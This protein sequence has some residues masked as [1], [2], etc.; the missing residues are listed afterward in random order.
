MTIKR[1]TTLI[2][3]SLIL[4]ILA[5]VGAAYLYMSAT[6]ELHRAHQQKYHSYLLADELRQSSDDLT[7]L[8]RTYVVT[9]DESYEAQYWDVLAIRNGEEPRP[10]EYWRIY[11]DFVAAGNAE[12]RPA[13]RTIALQ[14]LMRDAGFTEAEF[15]LLTQAQNNSDGLVA[16][17]TQAMNAVK[18]LFMDENGEYS[19]QGEPDMQQAAQLLHSA[20]YHRYKAEIM[21]PV[22]AFFVAMTQRTN[23]AVESAQQQARFAGMLIAAALVML[24]AS[25]GF[26]IWGLVSR[27]SRPL[28]DLSSVMTRLTHGESGLAVPCLGRR[29]E[30]GQMA[31]SVQYFRDG[32]A[33][34]EA[35][36][37][38]QEREQGNRL[39]KGQKLEQAIA[40]FEQ[41]IAAIVHG[42]SGSA[43]QMQESAQG[44]ASM[45]ERGVQRSASV[46]AA[47][48]EASTNVQSV[49]AA[50]EELTASI[51]EIGRQV[52]S[53]GNSTERAVAEVTRAESTMQGLSASAQKV[54]DVIS[55]IQAIAE[56]TNL[57]ALNATIEAARAGDAGKGFA[58]VAAEVKNLASQTQRATEDIADQITAI[59]SA[60]QEAV[61][62]IT[63]IAGAVSEVNQ[64]AS[65]ISSSV[66]QQACATQEINTNVQQA[67]AGTG[68]VANHIAGVNDAS[69]ETGDA[70]TRMLA[71]VEELSQQAKTLSGEV[72][73]FLGDIRAA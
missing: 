22:D 36:R 5:V 13:D 27:V 41:T 20:R 35:L 73:R 48:E 16:L 43:T 72:E 54:G 61:S 37:A 71:S 65:S 2:T 8:A 64:T 15:D 30:I 58:V 7:R 32:L 50:T 18:G 53:S 11:W 6:G 12:P 59:Q 25:V 55:L 4:S 49:A 47:T 70:A 44:M 66:Q 31:D 21:A 34:R 52:E 26:A 39:A 33:E 1:L 63:G 56:Q 46:A 24:A 19:L 69:R 38:E 9:G 40:G 42:L 68:E 62:V 45:A 10:Q 57:L 28:G 60:T 29:D 17:E 3:T 23:A 51:S 67:A 14:D